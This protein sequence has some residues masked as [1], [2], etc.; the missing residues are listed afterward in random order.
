MLELYFGRYLRW[1]GFGFDNLLRLGL[2]LGLGLLLSSR[3]G[4]VL[5]FGLWCLH[6]NL[7][8]GRLNV[9]FWTNGR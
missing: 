2:G 4:L 7:S 6:L 8:S 3:L 5:I 1:V 9:G